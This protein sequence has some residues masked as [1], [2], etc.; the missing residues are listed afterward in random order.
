MNKS[1]KN[2]CSVRC[3]VVRELALPTH[4]AALH[5]MRKGLERR[6]LPTPM[7]VARNITREV[8]PSLQI[9][10]AKQPMVTS[11]AVHTARHIIRPPPTTDIIR[12]PP[13]TSRIKWA[14]FMGRCLPVASRPMAGVRPITYAVI[15]GSAQ[16]TARM[17]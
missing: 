5:I 14:R 11:I 17:A 3:A 2:A 1:L 4:T 10:L 8:A 13:L 16:A 9:P 15:F 6:L 12:P 7:V